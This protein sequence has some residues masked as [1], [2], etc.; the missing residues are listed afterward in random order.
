MARAVK[1]NDPIDQEIYEI[2]RR[3]IEAMEGDRLS[4]L[5]D[6]TKGHY[7]RVLKTLTEKLEIPGKP[8]S[9]IVGEIMSDAAPL[10]FRAM[11]G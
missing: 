8:I 5:S 4:S 10:L 7:L 2:H 3:Y 1:L 9:E 6:E 11:Q